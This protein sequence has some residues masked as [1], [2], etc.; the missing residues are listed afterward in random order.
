[1]K[2]KVI[3]GIIITLIVGVGVVYGIITKTQYYVVLEK[4]DNNSPARILK[5]KKDNEEI[6][7]ESV[8]YLDDVFLCDNTN[9]SINKNDVK[10]REKL[11]VILKD[12]TVVKAIV[13]KEEK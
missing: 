13:K 9:P 4:I 2:K 6:E 7:F 1:M 8:Y 12:K 11:K 3:L 5:L 10:N